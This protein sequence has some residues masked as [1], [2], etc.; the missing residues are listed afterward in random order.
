MEIPVEK[1]KEY[2]VD[3]IDNGFEGEGIAKIDNFTIFIPGAIKGEKV[4]ILIVKVLS[5]HAFG[6]V[7]EIIEKS[8]TR[9][10]VDCDT[11]KR[12]G[13]CNMRHIKY[14]DTLKMKQNAVQALVN[15]TLK[16]KI[17]VKETIRNGKTFSL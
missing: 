15:K 3:I 16:N 6:K 1:N 12:C 17:E 2:I 4:K 14:E 5:S 7:Q 10:D 8:E 11:Y 13:G 9:Q